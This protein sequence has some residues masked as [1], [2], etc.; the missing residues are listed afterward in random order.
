[1]FTAQPEQLDLL[2]AAS[3]IEFFVHTVTNNRDPTKSTEYNQ[4]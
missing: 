3:D 4:D 2:G 1:L